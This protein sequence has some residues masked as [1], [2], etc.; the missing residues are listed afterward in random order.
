MVT[1]LPRISKQDMPRV[2]QRS[3][4]SNDSSTQRYTHPFPVGNAA[5]ADCKIAHFMGNAANEDFNI[6]RAMGNA[7][8]EDF[9]LI[10][11]FK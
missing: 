3:R 4:I 6:G 2:T 8:P 1:Q 7:I 9:K 10:V 5:I 11:L